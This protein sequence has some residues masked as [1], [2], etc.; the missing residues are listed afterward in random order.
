VDL[1]NYLAYGIVPLDMNDNQKKQFFS[2]A[3]SYF[4]KEPCLYKAYEDS[5]IRRCVPEEEASFIIS[6]CHDMPCRGRVSSDKIVAKIL[7][8]GICWQPYSRMYIMMSE[9]VSVLKEPGICQAGIK[10]P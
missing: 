7:Q 6:H 5:L 10:C 8:A 1:V 2:Q 3:K 9:L 4:L